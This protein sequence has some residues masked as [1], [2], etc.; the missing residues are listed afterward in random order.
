MKKPF[1]NPPTDEEWIEEVRL[2]MERVVKDPHL[3]IALETKNHT[4][5]VESLNRAFTDWF[6]DFY[7][8][9]LKPEYQ[10]DIYDIL[11]NVCA[12]YVLMR[13]GRSTVVKWLMFSNTFINDISQ[14]Y[15]GI[16]WLYFENKLFKVVVEL[17]QYE[18]SFLKETTS[19]AILEMKS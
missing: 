19:H 1:I 18:R 6:E 5:I 15:Q 13:R 4:H 10:S 17:K 8:F 12:K 7:L 9:V 3:Q 14:A 11:F 16:N 2:R